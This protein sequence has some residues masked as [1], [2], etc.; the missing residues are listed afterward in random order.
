MLAFYEQSSSLYSV[1]QTSPMDGQAVG[2]W[3]GDTLKQSGRSPSF[4][5]IMHWDSVSFR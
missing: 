3:R 5:K 1:A 2:S 4:A